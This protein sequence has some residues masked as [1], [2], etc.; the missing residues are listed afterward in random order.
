[1]ES[2]KQQIETIKNIARIDERLSNTISLIEISTNNL[3]E[4]LEDILTQA[5]IT[6]GRVN[7]LE[8]NEAE[9]RG[10]RAIIT[11]LVSALTAAV[12]GL[13]VKHF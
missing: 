9:N 2:T 6:N 4:K 8:R 10:R 5:K 12:T 13:I 3:M 1:M 7:I 11:V